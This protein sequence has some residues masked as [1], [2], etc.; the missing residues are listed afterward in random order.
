M[1]L[2]M[3]A[4]NKILW[5]MVGVEER[6]GVEWRRYERSKTFYTCVA[7]YSNMHWQ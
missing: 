4:V 1:R 5:E 7:E 2:D 6:S 3:T